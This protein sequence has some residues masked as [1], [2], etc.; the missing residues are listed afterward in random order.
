MALRRHHAVGAPAGSAPG[1]RPARTSSRTEHRL[2]RWR[3][4]PDSCHEA[5]HQPAA[6]FAL[7]PVLKHDHP[8]SEQG[9]V[10]T[11]SVRGGRRPDAHRFDDPRDWFMGV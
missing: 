8:S 10:A 9:E 4:G 7:L 2:D 6:L 5:R 1:R 3:P 11:G